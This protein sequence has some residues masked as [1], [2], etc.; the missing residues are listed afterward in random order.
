MNRPRISPE[1]IVIATAAIVRLV[2]FTWGLPDR[3]HFFSYHPDEFELAARAMQIVE[4]GNWNPEFFAYGS[5]YLYLTAILAWPF[6]AAGLITSVTGFHVVARLISVAAGTGA[7]WLLMRIARDLR[8]RKVA[9]LAGALLALAPAHGMHSRFATVD[10]T[11]TF[12]AVLTFW[13]AIR[14]TK[15]GSW[16]G[17]AAAGAAAG[18]AGA[19]K[20]NVALAI[21][22]PLLLAITSGGAAG[23]R[24]KRVGL[25]VGAATLA[26][27][28]A[29]P[30]A[31][32]DYP[33]FER[34]LSYELFEHPREGHRDYFDATGNG[35]GYHALHNLPY[36]LGVPGLLL[37]C[38]GIV[39]LVR[40]RKREELAL[41]LFAALYFLGLGFS[42]VRF[43]R[44]TL[45]LLPILAYAAAVLCAN[46]RVLL[47]VSVGSM[48]VLSLVQIVPLLRPDPRTQAADW[49]AGQAR[50]EATVG[51]IGIPWFSSPPLTV[52]N[53]G[54][55][56]RGRFAS[57]TT[58]RLV[59]CENWD[60]APLRSVR[61]EWFV[62]S[63]FDT[64]EVTRL[65]NEDAL[66]FLD[67]LDAGWEVAAEFRAMPESARR[68]FGSF[69]PHDWLY[70][71]A[72]V[73]VYQ[74]RDPLR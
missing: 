57:G 48:A 47:A 11:A 73:R 64:R 10:A 31:V 5:L 51:M 63:E 66:R 19:A 59:P 38:L 16:P 56:T 58:L 30:Y 43:M 9:W 61:P 39:A 72:T 27:L 8:G 50:P 37:A 69:A 25:I 71:Y 55:R 53:G 13:F 34:D 49:L 22:V 20:Y 29:V 23:D 54:E 28:I 41:L 1:W 70:P 2:G 32:L 42:L 24:A 35:W 17:F 67:E 14:A 60:P 68:L 4:T 21:V 18:L 65:G 52:W 26:F 40:E 33:S 62:V 44:Y 15:R 6:E 46:R 12:L 3:R 36:A 7:V 74:R 45:P